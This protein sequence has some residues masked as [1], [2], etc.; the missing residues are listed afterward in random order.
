ML[1]HIFAIAIKDLRVFAADKKSMIIS[2]L[3]PIAIA[4]FFTLIMGGSSSGTKDASKIPLVVVNEDSDPATDQIIEKLKSNDSIAV[5]VKDRKVAEDLVRDGKRGVAVI[6]PKGFSAQ[7]KSSLFAGTPPNL[8]EMYDPVK[9]IER[10]VVQ[11]ALMQTLMQEIPRASMSGDG[12]SSNLQKAMEAEADP[13]RKKSW[14]SMIDSMKSLNQ[15]GGT[16]P[17]NGGGMKQP[18]EIKAT[19]MTASKSENADQNAVRA[20]IFGGM[21]IQ[22]IMFFAI[23]AAM[24]LLS[25]RRKGIWTR[26]KA[27]PVSSMSLVLG[28]GLGSWLIALLIYI[29][30]IAFGMLVFGFRVEGSWLGL[31]VIAVMSALMTGSFGLFVASLGKT[32]AQSRGLS[33]LAVLMMSMLGGAW[34]PMSMMPKAVQTASM[35]IPVR[36]SVDGVDAVMSRGMG[37]AGVLVPAACLIGFS[38]LF[39]FVALLRLRKD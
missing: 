18:F 37:L 7:A 23:D 5:E 10:Q 24:G 22:G 38:V 26:M 13:G 12:A 21:A 34:F 6:F 1:Q 15:S 32:E 39:T 4:S 33:V 35:I 28:K 14:Q 25:D 17:Q 16:S 9:S 31:I 2:F 36:W 30:V 8:E 19:A 20:H 3:V 11:G 29:G 27:A